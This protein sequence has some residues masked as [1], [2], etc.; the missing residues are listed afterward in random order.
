MVQGIRSRERNKNWLIIYVGII[1][2]MGF[3]RKDLI[4]CGNRL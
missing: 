3:S 2:W 4:I 1:I